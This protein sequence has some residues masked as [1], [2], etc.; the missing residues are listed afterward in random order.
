[1]FSVYANVG[2]IIKTDYKEKYKNV[3]DQYEV[4]K[5]EN[6]K[7]SKIYEL[8]NSKETNQYKADIIN[9]ELSFTYIINPHFYD[10]YNKALYRN[11]IGGFFL[12]KN[13]YYTEGMIRYA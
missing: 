2:A 6:N 5:N 12:S 3:F 11:D 9:G 4:I 1:M 8:M 13:P 7:L 10:E